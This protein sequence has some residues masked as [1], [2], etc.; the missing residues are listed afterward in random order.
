[1][2]ENKNN[3]LKEKLGESG[4]AIEQRVSQAQED[5]VGSLKSIMTDIE[6]R[7]NAKLSPSDIVE[8]EGEQR[9]VTLLD[10]YKIAKKLVNQVSDFMSS[11]EKSADLIKEMKDFSL[12]VD[13]LKQDILPKLYIDDTSLNES[14]KK[15][16]SAI[17]EFKG[18]ITDEQF[19]S[20][21]GDIKKETGEIRSE[22]GFDKVGEGLPKNAKDYLHHLESK[23]DKNKETIDKIQTNLGSYEDVSES[24]Q[25]AKDYFNKIEYDIGKYV[26]EFKTFTEEEKSSLKEVNQNS[27]NI[28]IYFAPFS[29]LLNN[30]FKKAKL[31]NKNKVIAS[32]S[33]YFVVMIEKIVIFSVEVAFLFV[34]LNYGFNFNIL[35]YSPVKTQE[36][37][38]E[39]FDKVEEILYNLDFGDTNTTIFYPTQKNYI[40]FEHLVENETLFFGE[41]EVGFKNNNKYK[42]MLI[43]L[44]QDLN[45]TKPYLFVIQGS[46]S[47]ERIR[48][49]DDNRTDYNSNYELATARANYA[50]YLI[51]ENTETT[52]NTFFLHSSVNNGAPYDTTQTQKRNEKHQSVNIKIYELDKD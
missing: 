11:F 47:I 20:D 5:I 12:L 37:I 6:T 17:E 26:K 30:W 52:K 22:L 42:S 8:E 9:K 23:I 16:N 28:F 45:D 48:S 25:N 4:E 50:K 44:L 35:D 33:I 31:F 13:E 51:L 18:L 43:N 49:A 15:L 32:L 3:L 24:P 40:N 46:A 2:D 39:R 29:N 38:D 41:K 10:Y 7:L 21:I 34:F 27:K 1:M 36:T 14:I 19:L